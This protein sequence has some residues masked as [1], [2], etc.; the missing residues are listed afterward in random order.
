V[1]VILVHNSSALI[2][3]VSST[4]IELGLLPVCLS[5]SHGSLVAPIDTDLNLNIVPIIHD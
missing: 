3:E 1:H 5:L 2:I 4:H